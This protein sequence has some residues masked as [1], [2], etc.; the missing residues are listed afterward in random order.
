LE[1]IIG[2]WWLPLASIGTAIVVTFGIMARY[3]DAGGSIYFAPTV[4]HVL[5][6]A[7]IVASEFFR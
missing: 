6:I 4:M 2:L 5:L 1:G 7:A 3:G